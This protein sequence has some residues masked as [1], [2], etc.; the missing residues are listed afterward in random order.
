MKI[1]KITEGFVTNSSS[2]SGVMLIGVKKGKE[3][4][5]LLPK[6]GIPAKFHDRF[7]EIEYEEDYEDS[8]IEYDDLTDEYEILEASALLAAYGDDEAN[9]AP[10]NGEDNPLRWFIEQNDR[11]ETRRNLVRDDLILLYSMCYY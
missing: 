8:G 4:R 5:M 2:Y 11:T 3:L 10:P 1:I 9:G 6:I 7:G